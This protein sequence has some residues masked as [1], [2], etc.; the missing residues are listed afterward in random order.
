MTTQIYLLSAGFGTRLGELTR[1]QPK[2]L[3][4]IR[5]IPVL[6]YWLHASLLG[7]CSEV[8]VNTHYLAHKV[9]D[10][11]SVIRCPLNISIID[12]KILQGTAGSIASIASRVSGNELIVAHA[13]NLSDISLEEVLRKHRSEKPPGCVITM[14]LFRPRLPS[15]C[16]CVRLNSDGVVIE[17]GEKRIPPI[18]EIANA[19]VYVFDKEVVEWMS[20]SGARDI[21][22]DV[23]PNYIGRTWGVMH[24]G[25]HR[26]IG[27]QDELLLAQFDGVGTPSIFSKTWRDRYADDDV[28]SML[29]Q[30]AL[31]KMTRSE[32]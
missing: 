7:K 5:G 20:R 16:G 30:V 8:F 12:E 24:E 32:V 27:T 10:A 25:V 23:L 14:V 1:S 2:C 4:P 15:Q 9:H 3:M 22:N 19:A 18:S 28:H 29:R 17:F 31:K 13:D 26:D 6:E 11:L 21:S